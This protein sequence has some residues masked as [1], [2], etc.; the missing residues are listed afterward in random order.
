MLCSVKRNLWPITLKYYT[1]LLWV[2]CKTLWLIQSVARWFSGVST[3]CLLRWPTEGREASAQ[4]IFRQHCWRTAQAAPLPRAPSFVLRHPEPGRTQ[5][6]QHQ[7][8]SP[9]QALSS[10]GKSQALIAEP[11]DPDLSPPSLCTW[12]SPIWAHFK[13]ANNRSPTQS[14]DRDR[15]IL[16]IRDKVQTLTLCF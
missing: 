6:R 9:A 13:T 10:L 16:D 12:L 3:P 2:N 4:D 5:V 14:T 1:A 11:L 8:W 15:E 7:A